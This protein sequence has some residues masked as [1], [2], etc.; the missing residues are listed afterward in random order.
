[1]N[2]LLVLAKKQPRGCARLKSAK[3]VVASPGDQSE[4]GSEDRARYY[5]AK[6]GKR[7]KLQRWEIR[8]KRR[9]MCCAKSWRGKVA[10]GLSVKYDVSS[11]IVRVRYL[12]D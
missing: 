4:L 3:P 5:F 7:E 2:V 1:M 9:W 10:L 11:A 8:W 12:G 6:T